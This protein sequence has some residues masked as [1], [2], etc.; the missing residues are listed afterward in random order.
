M[1][2][3]YNFS[4]GPSVLPEAAL[5]A[6]AEAAIDYKGSGMSLMTMSH[7]SKPVE[8]IF[9]ETETLLRELL[10]V[11]DNFKILFLQG[12][13]SLQFCMVPMN[14]L[15]QDGVADFIDTGVWASKA[16]KEA[17]Q[18]GKVNVIASSKDAVYSFIPKEFEQTPNAT[19]LHITSNNTIYGTQW[20]SFPKPLNP[21]G[22]LVADMSSDILSRPFDWSNFGV[23]YAGAQKNMG[24]AG[25]TVVFV[26]EDI[27]GKSGRTLPTMLDYAT[28]IKDASMFN[29]PPVFSV[30]VINETL[31]WLKGLGG[32]K[33]IEEINERKANKLY[34]AIDESS[35]FK[36]PVA[37]ED[38][39]P[40]NVTFVMKQEGRDE[41][42]L[43]FC[44]ARGLQQLKGHR[45]VGGFR[46][47]I[48][49]AMPEEG[50]D[51]LIK[52]IKEFA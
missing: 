12:G 46:A 32:V 39:S 22:Y 5:K 13:A 11:P 6:A 16:A 47:S 35:L 51:E 17:K 4:A 25:A 45:S 42:F 23:V 50:V 15:P 40:M 20:K 33:K 52:A 3:I 7:R 38:R 37:K 36:N 10:K 26:R 1:K 31:K 2:K 48:Y 18:F 30:Y 21:N 27:L 29:T 9:A 24:P 43:E 34:K 41:E 14:L 19:Y 49:N 8:S 28:H 44:K